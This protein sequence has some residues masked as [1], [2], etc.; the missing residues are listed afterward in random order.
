MFNKNKITYR[1]KYMETTNIL[2]N[3]MLHFTP[4]CYIICGALLL[5]RRKDGD[6]SRILLAISVFVWGISM[7]ASL[8]YHYYDTESMAQPVLSM[9][10]LNITLFVYFIML[11][12]PIEIVKPGMIGVKNT[13]LLFSSWIGL[14]LFILIVAPDF[15]KLMSFQDIIQHIGEYNVLLRFAIAAYILSLSCITAFLPYK[16]NVSRVDIRWIRWFCFSLFISA[17][18]YTVWLL[19]G[20]NIVRL[21]MQIT[22]LAYCIYITYQELYVRFTLPEAQSRHINIKQN[23]SSEELDLAPSELWNKLKK[24][25]Q[26]KEPWLNPDLTLADM[27]LMIHSNR[28]TFSRVIRANGYDGFSSF[29]NQRRILEFIKIIETQQGIGINEAFF[30]VGFRSKTTALRHFREYTGMIPSE[31]IQKRLLDKDNH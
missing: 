14:N 11:L 17:L 13:I 27:V 9:I 6:K 21:L 2:F 26:E 19:T 5:I 22:C 3:L 25:M 16:Y 29:I 7:L 30:E 1:F 31:Y 10:S 12:Y 8:I 28:T 23:I 24:V 20:S 4:F 15:R 18:L